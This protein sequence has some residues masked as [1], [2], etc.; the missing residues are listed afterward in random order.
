MRLMLKAGV[1]LER[2]RGY[3]FSPYY[4]G[5]GR[6]GKR[7]ELSEWRPVDWWLGSINTVETG[8]VPQILASVN[9]ETRELW[10]YASGEVG[11][12]E[13]GQLAWLIFRMARDGLLDPVPFT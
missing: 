1:P 7:I 4:A 2:L 11:P 5:S 9:G 3:G 8:G 6:H 10:F 12:E 13:L